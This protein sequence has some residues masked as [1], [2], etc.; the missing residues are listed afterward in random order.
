M[1][2]LR[3]RLVVGVA[4]AWGLVLLTAGTTLFVLIRQAM[5]DEFDRRLSVEAHVLTLEVE[6]MQGRPHVD[7][8]HGSIS[9][10]DRGLPRETFELW[11]GR[12]KVLQRSASLG[13]W[14]LI[15]PATL[16]GPSP[17]EVRLPG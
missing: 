10:F 3:W 12:G 11:D 7:V 13:E 17:Q 2:S 1:H 14:H 4:L 9:V 6:M 5:E 8:E 15:G 16:V